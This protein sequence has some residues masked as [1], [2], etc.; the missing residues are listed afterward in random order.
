[1]TESALKSRM[2]RRIAMTLAAGALL[3]LLVLT[4]FSARVM[5]DSQAAA[6]ERRLTGVSQAYARSLRSRL[7][8]AETIVQTLTARDVGYDGSVLKQQI[9]NSRAFKSSVVVDRDG[10]LAG[11]DATLRPTPAQLLSLEAGRTVVLHFSLSGQLPA[12]FLARAVTAGG[13]ERLAYFEIAPDW[14]W[15]DLAGGVLATPVAIVDADG[16]VMQSTVPLM[17]ETG[18]MFGEHI[19]RTSTSN[20]ASHSLAWQGAGEEWRGVLT[21]LPLVDER[22]TT[23]PWAVVAMDRGT[24]FI[25]R[26]RQIWG[27]LPYIAGFALLVAWL[28]A[29]YLVRRHVPALR[30]VEDGLRRLSSRRFERLNVAASDETRSLVRAFNGTAASLEEQFRAMETLA[31][32]D[33]LLLGPAELEQMLESIL[34]RVQIVTRCHSVG[35]TL[36]DVDAPGRGRIYLAANGLTGL[37]VSRV[38]L[39]DDMVTTLASETNGLTVTRCEERRHSFLRPM[40]EIGAEFFWVWPVVPGDRVEAILAIGYREAPAIDPHV[41]NCGNAFAERLAIALSKTARDERLHR[42]AHYDPLTALP[43]RLLFLDRLNQELTSATAGLSRGALLY[44][45]LDHFKRVNDSVGHSAGDQL[46]TIV[47]Q[48]LRSCVKDG[49]TVARLGG[50]EFTVILRNVADPDQARSVAE[51]IIESVQLPVNIGGRD[52]YVCASIGITLFPDDGMSI[53]ELMR[54]ADTAMYRAKDLGR[55][56]AMFFDLAMTS[57][58]SAATET[59]LHRALRRREFSLFYQPQF[60][61]ADGSLTGLEAL[62]RWQTPRDGVRFP[63]EFVPAAEESGLIVDIGGWVLETACAQ[64]AEWRDQNIAPPRLALNV[65]AQQLKHAEFPKAVRRALDK[66][67]ISPQLLELE[68]T[69]SVFADE[70]AGAALVRLSQIGVHLAL[71]DFG[72]GYSSLNYLRQYPIGT[73]KIDR[74]FLE[75]VPQNPASATLV[76]TIVVMAHALGKRVV[77]EGIEAVEQLEFLRER[78]CD[79]AQG[80]YLSRP[81][82]ATAVTEIL[83]A[84]TIAGRAPGEIREVG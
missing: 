35:I 5:G 6:V 76:E 12:I 18:R 70:A 37:P 67:N 69:E 78:R 25:A 51:R 63:G 60:S 80:F 74:T 52:Q 31:Q 73:V 47:A 9:V 3:P 50:D 53:E 66:Y 71:D 15:K 2:G 77:A 42:Q 48:R 19:K 21:H 55:G 29:E 64:L 36:I 79:I 33:Q 46:L 32:I 11:G 57:K 10:L 43:N 27:A 24:T 56:R 61:V 30:A 75:E 38:A 83:Q 59:G 54:N 22:I 84:R 41:A 4:I 26:T 28:G 44:I 8:A 68:L 81:L 16:A 45:D 49:D 7:G 17:P 82:A 14:L 39:D 20:R 62:L 72:T 13:F 40:S 34:E 23:V 65:S 58:P 1:M